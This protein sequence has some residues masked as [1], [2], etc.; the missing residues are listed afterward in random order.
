MEISYF[1]WRILKAFARWFPEANRFAESIV[2]LSCFCALTDIN[3]S[4]STIFEPVT[5]IVVPFILVKNHHRPPSLSLSTSK[6]PRCIGRH[7]KNYPWNGQKD[8]Y[9]PSFRE[10]QCR[11]HAPLLALELAKTR[12]DWKG[13]RSGK[14]WR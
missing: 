10:K 14:L 12:P 7:P 5:T 8:K 6:K 13:Q 4:G 3:I 11:L 9:C 2:V 1:G